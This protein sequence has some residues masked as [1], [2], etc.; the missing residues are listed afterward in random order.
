MPLPLHC[1]C[2]F[3]S[4]NV[5]LA[6]PWCQFQ[7]TKRIFMEI[8]SEKI[9]DLKAKDD[10]SLHKAAKAAGRSDSRPP[11]TSGGPSS[12]APGGFLWRRSPCIAVCSAHVPIAPGCSRH[13]AANSCE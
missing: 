11:P 6:W 13:Q 3:V 7:V 4:C 2:P 10:E 9:Q 12:S 1:R 5:L 8:Q